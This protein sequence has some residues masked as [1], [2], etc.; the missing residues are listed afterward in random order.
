MACKVCGA[1]KQQVEFYDSINTFCKVHWRERVKE[2]RDS[3]I[4]Y[5]REFDR[6]RANLPHRLENTK[7]VTAK[8]KADHPDRRR[9]QVILGNAVRDGKIVPLH[10]WVCGNK[11]EAHRQ[12]HRPER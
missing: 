7:R 8:W 1:T 4:D 10:C 11:A 5:Y 6:N 3:K 12:S 2:N 9:A